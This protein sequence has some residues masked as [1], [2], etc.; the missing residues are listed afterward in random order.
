MVDIDNRIYNVLIDYM[1]ETGCT[2]ALK[3][4]N[5]EGGKYKIAIYTTRPGLFIGQGGS[6]LSKYKELVKK[7]D[8]YFDGFDI[9]E[10][11][12]ILSNSSTKISDEEY[13]V[14][15]NDFFASRGM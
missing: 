4:I 12:F 2:C 14:A 11:D 1:K 15:M 7:V 8:K 3:V 9:N 6:T 5:A 10:V 13:C